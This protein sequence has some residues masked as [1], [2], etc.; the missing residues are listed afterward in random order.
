ME[1]ETVQPN[2]AVEQVTNDYLHCCVVDNVSF[3]T[4]GYDLGII[5]AEFAAFN[6]MLLDTD[7]AVGSVEEKTERFLDSFFDERCDG[8]E[9][10]TG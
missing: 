7:P 5:L 4:P 3:V 10:W 8:A 1:T 2:E 6:D 9:Y